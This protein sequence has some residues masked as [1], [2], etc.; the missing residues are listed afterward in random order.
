MK[1]RRSLKL[2]A[3]VGL[4]AAA[5][6]FLNATL[7]VAQTVA[8]RIGVLIPGKNYEPVVA[9]LR[10]GLLK[11]G[12]KDGANVSYLVEVSVNES[13]ALSRAAEKLVQAKPDL[14][15]AVTTPSAL[16]VKHATSGLAVVFVSVG[17]PVES[18]LVAAFA[19]SGNNFTGI[20]SYVA[21]LSGKRLELLKEIAPKTKKILLISSSREE[22][23]Q[24][25]ARHSEEAARQFGMQ[26][27][28]RDMASES[29]FD[30]LLLER[31][32]GLVDAVSLVPS[33]LSG[34]YIERIIVKANQE[35]L[36]T[37]VYENTLVKMGALASYGSDRFSTGVQAANLVV[38]ILKGGK[39][40][41][42][43]IETPEHLIV[44]IN[45]ATAKV[46]GLKIP[47][48]VLER[49]DGFVD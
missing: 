32:A 22:I 48:P 43:P 21:S 41:D 25:S 5:N 10:D 33:A 7:A 16:A 3:A 11:L 38:K 36:P 24:L 49:A 18:G 14:I 42:I 27:L 2:L 1:N 6:G 39:P 17:V 13:L 9:G 34:S 46:I 15:F 29:D 35:R 23:S 12:Y 4:F 30:K 44:T 20:S 31:W 8:Q 28:R 47:G 26:I 45:R 19:S 40:R 37:I